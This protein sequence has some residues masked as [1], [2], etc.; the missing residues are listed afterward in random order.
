MNFF[1]TLFRPLALTAGYYFLALYLT[2]YPHSL[3]FAN[4]LAIHHT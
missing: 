2:C 1:T 3:H 4:I